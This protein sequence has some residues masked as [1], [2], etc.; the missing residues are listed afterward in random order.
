[1]PA[2]TPKSAAVSAWLVVAILGAELLILG[3][4]SLAASAPR[5][6]STMTFPGGTGKEI[7]VFSPAPEWGGRVLTLSVPTEPLACPNGPCNPPPGM[8]ARG[9]VDSCLDP[10]CQQLGGYHAD[11]EVYGPSPIQ[12]NPGGSPSPA[13]TFLVTVYQSPEAPTTVSLTAALAGLT[14]WGVLALWITVAGGLGLAAAWVTRSYSDRPDGR[15][16]VE[17]GRG[18]RCWRCGRFSSLAVGNCPRCGASLGG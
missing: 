18:I 10:N 5:N 9:A 4:V 16:P 2:E 12:L 7:V 3:V 6:S 11:W 15:S 1:M 8:D 14:S 17:D 13:T